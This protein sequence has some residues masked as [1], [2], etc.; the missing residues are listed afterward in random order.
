MIKL[1][2]LLSALLLA[3]PLAGCVARGT[4]R[5]G[6]VIP[7]DLHEG[8][9][10]VAHL[11][12]DGRQGLV[13]E[14]R[15][16]VWHAP[17][18]MAMLPRATGQRGWDVIGMETEDGAHAPSLDGRFRSL[19]LARAKVGGMPATL[20]F[21]AGPDANDP[22]P[23]GQPRRMTIRTLRL[24]ADPDSA[25]FEQ[26]AT[27]STRQPFCSP[28]EAIAV[29]FRIALPDDDGSQDACKAAGS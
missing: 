21:V 18:L 9:T 14:A 3:P 11:A 8:A 20:L 17:L 1:L 12:P 16:P 4:D 7:I 13:V 25:S 26:I 22:A 24:Q 23:R 2:P 5:V 29:T 27:Q 15:D 28:T 19:V 10:T 6:S